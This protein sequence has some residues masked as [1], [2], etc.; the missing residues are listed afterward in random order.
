MLAMVE[1]RMWL[2]YGDYLAI[3]CKA[4]SHGGMKDLLWKRTEKCDWQEVSR[5]L[6]IE[7]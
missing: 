3:Y 6:K 7:E 2:E 1:V 5:R 4:L